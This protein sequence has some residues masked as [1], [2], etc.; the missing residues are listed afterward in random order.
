MWC[1]CL[2]GIL[3]VLSAWQWVTQKKQPT[4]QTKQQ[5][6]QT[7]WGCTYTRELFNE[8]VQ[9]V[10]CCCL[11]SVCMVGSLEGGAGLLKRGEPCWEPRN[12]NPPPLSRCFSQVWNEEASRCCCDLASFLLC[13]SEMG[14]AFWWRALLA[15]LLWLVCLVTLLD[16]LSGGIL[17]DSKQLGKDH[18]SLGNKIAY[19]WLMICFS[20]VEIAAYFHSFT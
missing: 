14:F 11:H 4:N 16:V 10:W 2:G 1:A 19:S 18:I 15:L 6:Q 5:Q 12:F 17:A 7:L 8:C 20:S 3:L 9:I 13:A